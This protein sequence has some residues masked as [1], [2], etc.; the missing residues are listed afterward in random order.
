MGGLSSW[1]SWTP[2]SATCGRG[3]KRRH[4]HCGRSGSDNGTLCEDG[5]E[6]DRET[7]D[8]NLGTCSRFFSPIELEQ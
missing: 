1:V 7:A 5:S 2:C 8:C 3:T 6:V 4:R